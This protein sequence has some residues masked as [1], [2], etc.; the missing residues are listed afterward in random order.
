M[1]NKAKVQKLLRDRVPCRCY[2]ESLSVQHNPQKIIVEDLEQNECQ[3][4]EEELA[5][6]RG[7]DRAPR[8]MYPAKASSIRFDLPSARRHQMRLAKIA[9]R[10]L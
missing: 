6:Q 3:G 7:G 9:Q 10:K 2:S 5:E 4:H 1:G 8:M